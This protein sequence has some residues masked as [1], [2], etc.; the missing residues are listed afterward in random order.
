M[1]VTL[2]TS[3]TCQYC[4]LEKQ[5][6]KKHKIRFQERNV[7]EYRFAQEMVNRTKQTAVPAAV[8]EDNGVERIVIGFQ[9]EELVAIFGITA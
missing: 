9:E 2:Y 8:I 4:K 5:F 3:P 7:T 6:L 1:T